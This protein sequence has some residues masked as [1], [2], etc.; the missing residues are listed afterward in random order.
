M[1]PLIRTAATALIAALLPAQAIADV[2]ANPCDWLRDMRNIVEPWEENTRT[3]YNGQ[4]RVVNADSG[5]PACCSANL[6]LLVP[7]PEDEMEGDKCV[8]IGMGPG[9]GV[10]RLDYHKL[11]ADYDPATGLTLRFPYAIL[12]LETSRMGP[13]K[14][15]TVRINLKTGEVSAR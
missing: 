12:N 11:T 8:A 9:M 6:L 13:T 1:R 10:T 14:N 15:A 5:E 3:F 7:D 4:V 2:Q